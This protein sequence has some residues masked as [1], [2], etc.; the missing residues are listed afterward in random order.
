TPTTRT[1]KGTAGDVKDNPMDLVRVA[2]GRASNGELRGAFTT[3]AAFSIKS[4]VAKDGVPG[5]VCLRLW[6]KTK[7]GGTPPDYLV[8]ATAD[9]DGKALDASVLQERT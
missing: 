5:S 9:K 6:T 1:V 8:C 4:M 2:L 3:A 7:P